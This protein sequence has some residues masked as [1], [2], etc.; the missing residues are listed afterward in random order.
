MPRMS[1]VLAA[2]TV[3]A[4]FTSIA[5]C[6]LS[7]KASKR[8]QGKCSNLTVSS[9]VLTPH[10]VHRNSVG[11]V[12]SGNRPVHVSHGFTAWHTPSSYLSLSLT[13]G[14]A[15]RF[16]R[17]PVKSFKSLSSHRD[18][19]SPTLPRFGETIWVHLQDWIDAHS[20]LTYLSSYTLTEKTV[21]KIIC[22]V[23][24]CKDARKQPRSL[25]VN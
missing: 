16:W 21:E 6:W 4:L 1:A 19:I 7:C 11:L 10:V 17:I 20:N 22:L 5:H 14:I 18:S 3:G 8:Y 24:L 23:K 15:V 12:S 25:R 13:Y 9:F 2:P